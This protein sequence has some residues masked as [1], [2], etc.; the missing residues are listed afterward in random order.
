MS[1]GKKKNLI[2]QKSWCIFS[3]K[4]E[5]W[6]FFS[7]YP[8]SF[9]FLPSLHCILRYFNLLFINSSVFLISVSE[10]SL[11][12]SFLSWLFQVFVLFTLWTLYFITELIFFIDYF[13]FQWQSLK[14]YI[15]KC[16]FCL[17]LFCFSGLN[18]SV[19]AASFLSIYFS[20]LLLGT[21]CF[22]HKRGF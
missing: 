16:M 20:F 15:F 19:L 7:Y 10:C 6:K 12:G 9:T 5:F 18:I 22:E 4:T 3:M 1:L 2:A 13:Q 11:L 8:L 17:T 21:K 14:L